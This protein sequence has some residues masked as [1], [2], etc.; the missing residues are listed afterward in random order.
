MGN[1]LLSGLI[2]VGVKFFHAALTNAMTELG[3]G[4]L[5]NIILHLIPVSLVIPDSLAVHADRYDA[6]EGLDFGFGLFEG[7]VFL[8]EL[9]RHIDHLIGHDGHLLN[10]IPF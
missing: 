1:F 3:I 6:A 10:N 8:L 5:A 2:G 9:P 7:P 4:M